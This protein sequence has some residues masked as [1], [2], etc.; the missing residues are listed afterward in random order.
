[1]AYYTIGHE[2]GH[3]VHGHTAT[4]IKTRSPLE[5]QAMEIEADGYSACLSVREALRNSRGPEDERIKIQCFFLAAALYLECDERT[6]DW[7][8]FHLED[9]PPYSIRIE[10]LQGEIQE[11]FRQLRPQDPGVLDQ[12]SA[13]ELLK[14]L[15]GVW[16]P[17]NSSTKILYETDTLS[18]ST[19]IEYN[20]NL[21]KA[22]LRLRQELQPTHLKRTDD[23]SNSGET[24]ARNPLNSCSP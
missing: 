18:P 19:H 24:E 9:Y 20:Q 17:I 8:S 7:R 1:M 16:N 15:D 14:S 4:A 22:R 2:L 12:D 10:Y 11:T 5:R 3:H 13:G 23:R 21:H 6:I